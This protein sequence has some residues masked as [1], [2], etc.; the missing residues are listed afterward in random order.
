MPLVVAEPV[1]VGSLVG[2]AEAGG[3]AAAPLALPALWMSC[4]MAAPE[5]NINASAIPIVFRMASSSV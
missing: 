1:V 2:W 4:A 5:A 3:A